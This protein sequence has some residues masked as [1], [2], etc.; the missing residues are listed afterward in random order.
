[1]L[2]NSFIQSAERSETILDAVLSRRVESST[3]ACSLVT[4]IGYGIILVFSSKTA[5]YDGSMSW[6]FA[7]RAF[8]RIR[9]LFLLNPNSNIRAIASSSLNS[10]DDV[11]VG[12]LFKIRLSRNGDGLLKYPQLFLVDFRLISFF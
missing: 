3:E 7:I 1:M 10:L 11:G 5:K 8:L 2:L 12:I 4:E 9:Y 6:P